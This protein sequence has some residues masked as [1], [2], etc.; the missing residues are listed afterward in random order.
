MPLWLRSAIQFFHFLAF[1]ELKKFYDPNVL[2]VEITSPEKLQSQMA[3]LDAILAT[4]VMAEV[5]RYL[6][7]RKLASPIDEEF[8]EML[9]H[10]WFT[11]IQRKKCASRQCYW[12][13]YCHIDETHVWIHELV[14]SFSISSFNIGVVRSSAL[15]KFD[16]FFSSNEF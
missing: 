7:D 6:E 8:K 10:L 14:Y 5:R 4:P 1:I 16:W 13:L 11:G 3:F 9:G 12:C 2:V 15:L